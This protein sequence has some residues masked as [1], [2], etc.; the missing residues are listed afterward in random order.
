MAL[1]LSPR[2]PRPAVPSGLM[3]LSWPLRG[4]RLASFRGP[5]RRFLMGIKAHR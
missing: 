1:W 2:T 4:R 5:S 3:A